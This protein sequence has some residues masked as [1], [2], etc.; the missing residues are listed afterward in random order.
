MSTGIF[1]LRAFSLHISLADM[2]QLR[3]GD[4]VDM[5]IEQQ[6]DNYQYPYAATQ[7]DFDKFADA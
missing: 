1:A 4:V 6:N 2:E 7:E 5:I 3:H